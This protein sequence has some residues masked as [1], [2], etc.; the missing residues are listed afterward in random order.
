[1][2]GFA[3]LLGFFLLCA[4]GLGF[5][6]AFKSVAHHPL[7]FAEWAGGIVGFALLLA[8]VFAISKLPRDQR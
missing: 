2:G 6:A 7:V 4:I 8:G 3:I 1:M 5:A